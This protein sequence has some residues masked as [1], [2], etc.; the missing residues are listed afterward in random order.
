MSVISPPKPRR[1]SEATREPRRVGF[2]QR[3]GRWDV[4]L[5]PYL[6]VSPF[7]VLFAVTGLFPLVYTAFVSVHE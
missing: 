1:A 2:R 4:K 5:S 7:F 6:Y 3:L